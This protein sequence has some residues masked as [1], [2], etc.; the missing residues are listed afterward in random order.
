MAH[1]RRGGRRADRVGVFLLYQSRGAQRH[2][3]WMNPADAG[4]GG[5][6]HPRGPVRAVA[7]EV[8][9]PA[10]Q[11]HPGHWGPLAGDG[12]SAGDLASLRQLLQRGVPELP[13]LKREYGHRHVGVQPGGPA[14]D[15]SSVA[16]AGP[17][18]G[19][20]CADPGVAGNH[21]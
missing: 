4:A 10:G 17:A 8:A 2:I 20:K 1:H 11:F 3:R 15:H 14:G 7:D 18:R 9:Q 5:C 21:W 16:L 12:Q 13:L 6:W 19:F